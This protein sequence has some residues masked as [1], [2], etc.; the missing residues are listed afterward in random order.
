MIDEVPKRPEGVI[1][2]RPCLGCGALPHVGE[3]LC[4]ARRIVE[5]TRELARANAEIA[6]FKR[7]A[8][9]YYAI[10]RR[11]GNVTR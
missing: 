8:R 2:V 11:A 1:K 5:L 3:A 7:H 10:G 6:D 9:E 4:Y